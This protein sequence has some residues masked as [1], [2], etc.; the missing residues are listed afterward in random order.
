MKKIL[1]ISHCSYIGGAEVVLFR[2]LSEVKYFRPFVLVPKGPLYEYF[3][4]SEIKLIKSHFM[5]KLNKTNN[6]LWPLKF[7]YTFLFSQFEIIYFILKYKPDIVQANTFYAMLYASLPAKILKKPVI[8]HMHDIFEN[9]YS[10]L[11]LLYNLFSNHIIAVSN[12][13]KDFLIKN[14]INKTKISVIYNSIGSLNYYD[15]KEDFIKQISTINKKDYIVVGTLGSIEERKGLFECVV[16]ISM[17]CNVILYIAGEA[18]NPSQESYKQR[19]IKYINKKKINDKIYFL[20]KINNIKKY[21]ELIDVFLHYPKH[22][23]PLPTVI[24]EALNFKCPVI[25]SDIGGNAECVGNGIWGNLIPP[26]NPEVLANELANRNFFQINDSEFK[27]F[28]KLF[29]HKYK[30]DEH[31]KIYKFL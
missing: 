14:G 24:L 13:V 5:R 3:N 25:T 23:D 19:I 6:L 9:K 4:K 7:I 15:E 20:G 16:A 30:E 31:L 27:K 26:N 2:F 18:N 28:K 1:F 8:W 17:L 12:P 10:N 21:F 22:P 11:I 29:S